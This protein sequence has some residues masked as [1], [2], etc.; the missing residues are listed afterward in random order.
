MVIVWKC[1]KCGAIIECPDDECHIAPKCECGAK[2]ED[3]ELIEE[4]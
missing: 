4:D 2:A 1:L 3:M